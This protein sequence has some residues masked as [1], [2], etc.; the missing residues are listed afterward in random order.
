MHSPES[1]WHSP[2][3]QFV[4]DGGLNDMGVT[5]PK[6]DY[7]KLFGFMRHQIKFKTNG[8]SGRALNSGLLK[9]VSCKCKYHVNI[10]IYAILHNVLLLISIVVSVGTSITVR[11]N[12]Y[13]TANYDGLDNLF[14]FS[15]SNKLSTTLLLFFGFFSNCREHFC[16]Q[17]NAIREKFEMQSVFFVKYLANSDF[18]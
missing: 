15:Y 1:I 8:S 18:N 16:I 2:T 3:K 6:H 10:F 4:L 17:S 11:Y 7:W 12:L 14:F 13:H 9:R 5:S